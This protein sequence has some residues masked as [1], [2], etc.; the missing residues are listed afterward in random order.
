MP[1][2]SASEVTIKVRTKNKAEYTI[3]IPISLSIKE[4]RPIISSQ[5]ALNPNIAAEDMAVIF[6]GR[7]M[8]HSRTIQDIGIGNGGFIVVIKPTKTIEKTQ[9]VLPGTQEYNLCS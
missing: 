8:E 5:C 9:V 1:K 3:T 2:K 6:K 4:L 7:L